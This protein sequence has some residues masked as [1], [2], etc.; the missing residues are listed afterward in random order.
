M[1]ARVK[2]KHL[3]ALSVIILAVFF[4][5]PTY[6]DKNQLIGFNQMSDDINGTAYRLLYKLEGDTYQ[7][8]FNQPG[9]YELSLFPEELFD[10]VKTGDATFL[11]TINNPKAMYEKHQK[12]PFKIKWLINE[13]VEF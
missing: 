2:V 4:I 11:I 13:I 1:Q 9:A 12:E 5:T 7:L 10:I 3:K 8:W 6:A